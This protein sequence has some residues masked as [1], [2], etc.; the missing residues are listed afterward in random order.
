MRLTRTKAKIAENHDRHMVIEKRLHRVGDG[1][2]RL[3]YICERRHGLHEII[4]WCEKRLGD[5]RR[6][7]ADKADAAAA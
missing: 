3:P 6:F 1:R 2:P 5:V 7:A 4:G